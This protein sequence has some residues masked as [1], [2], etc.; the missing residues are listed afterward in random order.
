MRINRNF[1]SPKIYNYSFKLVYFESKGNDKLIINNE[2]FSIKPGFSIII[3]KNTKFSIK[4]YDNNSYRVYKKNL[5]LKNIFSKKTLTDSHFIKFKVIYFSIFF[6][7]LIITIAIG[8]QMGLS[9]KAVGF[10]FIL[11]SVVLINV[12]T[13]IEYKNDLKYNDF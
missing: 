4:S 2:I 1:Q 3:P 11:C 6:I 7:V 13:Y 12:F 8:E 10:A 5:V 9:A